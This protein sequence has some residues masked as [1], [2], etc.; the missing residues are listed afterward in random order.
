MKNPD[1]GITEERGVPR[2]GEIGGV[3]PEM[4]IGAARSLIGAKTDDGKR[5]LTVDE[6][7]F[8]EGEPMRERDETPRAYARGFSRLTAGSFATIQAA[9]V[10]NLLLLVAAHTSVLSPLTK[11]PVL[12]TLSVPQYTFSRNSKRT[13]MSLLVFTLI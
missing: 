5:P 2:T 8:T 10:Q 7:E 12:H 13:F 1:G 11:N 9:L 6:R 4:E 3:T